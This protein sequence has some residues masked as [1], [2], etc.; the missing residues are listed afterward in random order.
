MVFNGFYVELLQCFL[1]N[2]EQKATASI[3]AKQAVASGCLPA[4]IALSAKSDFGEAMPS[5]AERHYKMH[6]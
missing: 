5:V 6:Q 3:F 1:V 2:R 4:T